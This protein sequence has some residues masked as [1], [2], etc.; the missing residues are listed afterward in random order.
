MNIA[1][2][3]LS[4][5]AFA[6]IIASPALACNGRGNCENAPGQNKPVRGAPGPLV[7]AAGLPVLAVGYGVF[8]LVR[9][10][11]VAGDAARENPRV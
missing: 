11:R 1:L 9:R 4:A 10:R 3:T 8:W 2:K 6:V 5:A 7:G